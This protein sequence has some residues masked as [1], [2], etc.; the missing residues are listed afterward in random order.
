MKKI[1]I[2]ISFLFFAVAAFAAKIPALTAP[3]MD[4]AGIIDAHTES[5]LNEYLLAVQKKTGMQV[6]VLTVPDLG[7]KSIEE[8][9]MSVAEKW[10]LGQKEEDNG[11]LLTV[12]MEE[13]AL[14]IEV[15]YGLEGMLT[16]TKCG[17][18]IRNGITP[19]F[20]DGDYAQGIVNG[21]L[22]IV[23]VVADDVTIDTDLRIEEGETDTD[24]SDILA[25]AWFIFIVLMMIT[26]RS[27]VGPLGLYWWLS[28][29]TGSK[30][31]RHYPKKDSFFNTFGGSSSH[32][33]GGFGGGFG[34][35]GFHGGGGGF[36]GGG[37]SGRW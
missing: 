5:E 25:V 26:S 17:L 31:V 32:H 3:V 21:V 4:T 15:G 1:A 10:Q 24:F 11:V 6:A 23:Q 29:L 34:G 30:F 27:G 18:I 19:Y 22:Q 35:G 9:S 36:G 37:A 28:M 33:H 20:K 12:A 14:R 16:D 7:G 2:G 13:H 8:F